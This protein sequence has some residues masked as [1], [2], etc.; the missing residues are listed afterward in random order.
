MEAKTRSNKD[1]YGNVTD[2]ELQRYLDAIDRDEPPPRIA[3]IRALPYDNRYADWTDEELQARL[4][5]LQ[6]KRRGGMIKAEK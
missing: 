2:E 3:S 4:D 1:L 6:R 5:E